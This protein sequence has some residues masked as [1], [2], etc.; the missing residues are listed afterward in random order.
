MVNQDN[1]GSYVIKGNNLSFSA[2][3]Q[4]D[5]EY[6]FY[7]RSN[8][9]YNKHLSPPPSTVEMQEKWIAEYLFRNKLGEEYYFLIR[10]LDNDQRCGLVRIYN[11]QNQGF[12]W[13]SWILDQNKPA[14]AAIDS[15]LLVYKFAF[16][17]LKLDFCEFDVRKSNIGTLH[18]HD[19][20]G[21][22]RIKEDSSDIYF[23]FSSAMWDKS[24]NLLITV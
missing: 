14:K 16:E 24:K 4:R 22:T 20:F 15:A 2:V 21:A 10:R 1:L 23:R 7:L 12:T 13:G 9:D 3:T 5:A 18:F 8:P 19:S 17:I 6:I 11:I